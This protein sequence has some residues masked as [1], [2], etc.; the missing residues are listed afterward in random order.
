MCLQHPFRR[1]RRM[2]EP[3]SL[4]EIWIE[5]EQL[6]DLL[7]ILP[8]VDV[9]RDGGDHVRIDIA[10]P[11][12]DAVPFFRALRRREGSLMIEDGELLPDRPLASVRTDEERINEALGGLLFEIAEAT[13]PAS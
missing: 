1:V 8:Y 11:E 3:S 2:N 9:K 5:E 10:A 12:R 4:D 7:R 6:T 13:R